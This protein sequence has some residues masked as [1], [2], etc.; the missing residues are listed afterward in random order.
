[1]RDAEKIARAVAEA[2][3]RQKAAGLPAPLAPPA[4]AAPLFLRDAER[5]PRRRVT[6]DGSRVSLRG[7]A[8]PFDRAELERR[9]AEHP[10]LASADAIGRLFVQDA[11]LPVV[12]LVGGP[13]ELAYWAQ[14]RAAAL[15]CG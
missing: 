2:G 8:A 12:A 14:V 6:L 3:E 1:V 10:A 5:G 4:G 9:V 7:E 13:T 15:A 11:L